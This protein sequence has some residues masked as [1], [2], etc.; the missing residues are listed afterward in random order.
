M[1]RPQPPLHRLVR[2]QEAP[3]RRLLVADVLA[4]VAHRVVHPAEVVVRGGVQRAEP[5]PAPVVLLHRLEVEVGEAPVLPGVGELVR[6]DAQPR[7]AAQVAGVGPGVG[8]VLADDEGLV[9]RE[10]HPVL[11]RKGA[12]LVPLLLGHELQPGVEAD[13]VR[14]PLGGRR[15][16][17][18]LP[19]ADPAR[20]LPPRALLLVLGQGGV[21]RVAVEPHR[22]PLAVGLE[23]AAGVGSP[24]LEAAERASTARPTSPGRPRRTSPGG[25]P[26]PPPGAIA[27]RPRGSTRRRRPGSRGGSRDG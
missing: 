9:A 8:A 23:A 21:E 6:R 5:E 14:Q 1:L 2:R 25:Q 12:R 7:V 10:E 16:G 20:P 11:P 22:A 17:L 27:P 4:E 13:P 18:R 15:E 19:L 3:P 26:G 24:L